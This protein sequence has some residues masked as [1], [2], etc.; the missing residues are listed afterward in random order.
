MDFNTVISDIVAHKLA[1]RSYEKS[2]H[3]KF[4]DRITVRRDGLMIFER[5]NYGEAAGLVCTM[6]AKGLNAEGAIAWDY[7]RCDYTGKKEA[8]ATLTAIEDSALF[9]D[10]KAVPWL[11]EKDLKTMPGMG[12]LKIL[13]SN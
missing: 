3:G 8:P 10:G 9:F 7:A 5:F 13:F 11:P 6:E 12:R 4:R 2:G 1:G